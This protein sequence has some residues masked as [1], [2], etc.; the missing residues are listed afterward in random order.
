L[1]T[2]NPAVWRAGPRDPPFAA[3]RKAP[4]VEGHGQR[5]A[6]PARSN[7]LSPR[8]CGYRRGAVRE[9]RDRL[10]KDLQNK[11][12]GLNL[13]VAAIVLWNTVYL[14]QAVA[15]LESQ[16]TPV[17]ADCLR[18]LWPLGWETISTN[19]VLIVSPCRYRSP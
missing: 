5:P 16:G 12:S 14:E 17:P 1:S 9:V 10:R 8:H 15:S 18:H 11:A 3:A 13:V 7:F 19:S 2:K 4:V 6:P